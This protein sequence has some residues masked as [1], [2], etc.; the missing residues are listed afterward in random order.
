MDPNKIRNLLALT[1]ANLNSIDKAFAG[2]YRYGDST[3]N[4]TVAANSL[5]TADNIMRNRL[6]LDYT[7]QSQYQMNN[8]YPQ[9]MIPQIPVQMPNQLPQEPTIS[10]EDRINKLLGKTP[11]QQA[12]AA[13]V[14]TAEYL[15]LVA[16]LREVLKPVIEQLEDIAIISGLTVQR[17]ETL[18]KEVNPEVSFDNNPQ[19]EPAFQQPTQELYE[20]EQM[21]VY[22]PE[23]SM[24]V[25]D[26]EDATA[27]P[28]PKKKRN[29][30]TK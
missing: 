23:V 14:Q 17:L 30:K 9:Q 20:E 11:Q 7:P 25:M 8:Y 15:Q 22:N 19:T 18:I 21:E 13:P 4:R 1:G 29:K 5:E 2:D 10:R 28:Q 3:G 24:S 26:D 27:T 6:G 16:A 12:P